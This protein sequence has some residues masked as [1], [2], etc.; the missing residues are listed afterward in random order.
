MQPAVTFLC[1]VCRQTSV[2]DYDADGFPVCP[3]CGP[4][5]PDQHVSD[6]YSPTV[7]RLM[8]DWWA[9]KFEPR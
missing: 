1:P 2:A 3:A 7:N 4:S 5:D 6:K 9:G 8:R